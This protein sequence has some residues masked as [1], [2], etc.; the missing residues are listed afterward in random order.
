MSAFNFMNHAL[1]QFGQG[2]AQDLNLNFSGPTASS[3][4][5]NPAPCGLSYSNL[6]TVTT[7]KPL[8]KNNVPR[9]IEF[10]LKYMF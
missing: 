4:G 6:N 7:G 5:D 9:V 8:Y 3:C 1:W 2:G 10:A